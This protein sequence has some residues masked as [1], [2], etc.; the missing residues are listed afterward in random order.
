MAFRKFSC[1]KKNGVGW[2]PKTMR[3]SSFT[4]L[5]CWGRA[6][7]L[8]QSTVC[9]SPVHRVVTWYPTGADW[10]PWC[11]AK[12]RKAFLHLLLPNSPRTLTCTLTRM[13]SCNLEQ[14]WRLSARIIKSIKSI[15]MWW[16]GDECTECLLRR[17]FLFFPFVQFTLWQLPAYGNPTIQSYSPL[18]NPWN[19][20]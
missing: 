7:M 12:E 4:S 10:F 13:H 16:K 15:K 8:K 14:G 6:L 17:G 9:P 20:L 19:I 3:N 1:K 18:G 11:S 2:P 5:T